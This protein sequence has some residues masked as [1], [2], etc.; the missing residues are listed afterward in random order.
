MCVVVYGI[1]GWFEIDGFFLVWVYVFVNIY[2][3]VIY[4]C[5]FVWVEEEVVFIGWNLWC[6]F[7][8][9]SI[10][11]VGNWFGYVLFFFFVVYDINIV[12][13]FFIF[14]VWY[15]VYC[16]FVGSYGGCIIIKIG[17][18]GFVLN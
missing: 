6:C 8:V 2:I 3:Y 5:V 9:R 17:V 10:D 11:R 4:V 14:V 15:K 12:G 7:V 18:D 1:D 16:I 13:V